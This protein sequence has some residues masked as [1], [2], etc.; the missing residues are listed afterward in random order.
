MISSDDPKS[1]FGMRGGGIGWGMP[2]A[3]GVKLALP[4]RPVLPLIGDGSS[5]YT[6]Q[7]LWTAA[8]YSIPV[9]W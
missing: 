3:L 1:F 6:I 7:A 9:I 8:R 5:L 2:A 4:E